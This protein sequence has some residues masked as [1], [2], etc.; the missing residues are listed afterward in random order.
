LV[1]CGAAV[2]AEAPRA[3]AS[4]GAADVVAKI[5]GPRGEVARGSTI[6]YRATVANKGPDRAPNA[7]G[8]VAVD[9]PS[10]VVSV[11]TSKGTCVR[12]K[13]DIRGFSCDFGTL[14]AGGKPVRLTV[15]AALPLEA[16]RVVTTVQVA[17]EAPGLDP[18]GAN[19]VAEFFTT[20]R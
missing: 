8:F 6:T 4:G 20:V 18:D 2:P 10:R 17:S 1:S 19:N 7:I 16:G 12:A 3:A 13:S 9:T 5:S 14:A 11:T 15:R